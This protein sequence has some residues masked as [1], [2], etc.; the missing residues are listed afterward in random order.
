MKSFVLVCFAGLLAFFFYWVYIY[1]LGESHAVLLR[2]PPPSFYHSW[3][4][5]RYTQKIP[6]IVLISLIGVT[7]L[8]Y[9]LRGVYKFFKKRTGEEV[10]P[11]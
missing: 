8:R 5:M 9:A 11:T 10:L 3:E 2:F 7:F 4:D 6:F 1:Y